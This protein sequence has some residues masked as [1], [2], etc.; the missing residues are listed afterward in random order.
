MGSEFRLRFGFPKGRVVIVRFRDHFSFDPETDVGK[1]MERNDKEV[2]GY[3][4]IGWV[5][6]EDDHYL[7]VRFMRPLPPEFQSSVSDGSGG[8]AVLKA[9]IVDVQEIP[10]SGGIPFVS[11][12]EQEEIKELVGSPDDY[13]EGFDEG[14]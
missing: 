7:Y 4:L 10:F 2:F 5:E 1:L 9:A 14:E 8:M 12:E 11:D 13:R 6:G 3:E